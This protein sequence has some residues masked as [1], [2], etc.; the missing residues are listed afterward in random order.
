MVE[1]RMEVKGMFRM[2]VKYIEFV[3]KHRDDIICPQKFNVGHRP[4]LS[5]VKLALT[6]ALK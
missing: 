6:L 2:T 1:D 4:I 5:D 3:L